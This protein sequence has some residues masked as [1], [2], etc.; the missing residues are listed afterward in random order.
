[1]ANGTAA[2]ELAAALQ[3]SSQAEVQDAVAAFMDSLGQDAGQVE[4]SNVVV[5][6]A[7]VVQ[8]GVQDY[9]V[10]VRISAYLYRPSVVHHSQL[11]AA[12][13][14]SGV[15][16]ASS[17]AA[18][19]LLQAT[20]GVAGRILPAPAV[21]QQETP[22]LVTLVQTAPLPLIGL[23]AAAQQVVV[24]VRQ[25]ALGMRQLHQLSQGQTV[26]A[27]HDM[28]RGWQLWTAGSVREDEAQAC[29]RPPSLLAHHVQGSCSVKGQPPW[30]SGRTPSS[31]ASRALM[32][33]SS[34]SSWDSLAQSIGSSTG[35]TVTTTTQGQQQ[36][37]EI[38]VSAQRCRVT[39]YLCLV[40]IRHPVHMSDRGR[41]AIH[42]PCI[43]QSHCVQTSSKPTR[44]HLALLFSLLACHA[45]L[46]GFLGSHSGQPAAR[47]HQP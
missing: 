47:P 42:R 44:R 1:M 22:A 41:D 7:A 38:A 31:H 15:T 23:Q 13:S 19:R 2:E 33:S 20:A 6:G 32:Q 17:S 5:S 35:S 12:S 39:S 16:P 46:P 10:V 40:W 34:A 24:L 43:L 25:A 18:R 45:G 27:P 9:D 36:V 4:A 11:Q 21:A 8:N 29:L 14:A 37:D 3:N 26:S 28:P 30:T